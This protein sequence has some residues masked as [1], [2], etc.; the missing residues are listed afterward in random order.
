MVSIYNVVCVGTVPYQL[1]LPED[2]G[3]SPIRHVI[4]N[5]IIIQ[6]LKNLIN[7]WLNGMVILLN[8]Q[9]Y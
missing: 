7:A 9:F 4:K 2:I 6:T 1:C 3:S 5:E 8:P